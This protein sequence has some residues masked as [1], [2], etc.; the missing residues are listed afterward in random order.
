[1]QEHSE[2]QLLELSRWLTLVAILLTS[3][4][5]AAVLG[6]Q[7]ALVVAGKGWTYL[8]VREIL[9]ASAQPDQE[10]VTG[11]IRYNASPVLDW[12]LDLPAMLLLGSAVGL[13]VV[14][15][16]YLKSLAMSSPGA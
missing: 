12:V 6:V 13:L 7:F 9:Q 1:M 11:G 10:D 3:I 8:S 15:Y 5:T 14:Y 16:R 4:C 2:R